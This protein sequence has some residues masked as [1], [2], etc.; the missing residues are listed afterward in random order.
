MNT[1]YTNLVI[2]FFL[3]CFG[4]KAQNNFTSFW[5]PLIS[6]NHKV[7]KNYEYNFGFE[8][9]S[10]LY[11]KNA[12]EFKVRQFDLSH[13]STFTIFHNQKLSLGV[14]YRYADEFEETQNEVRFT[15]QYNFTYNPHV[16]R[17]GHRVRAEQHIKSENT[18]HRFRYRFALDF[19]LSGEK[20]D[21][22]ESYMVT[23]AEMLY[24]IANNIVPELDTRL[25]LEIGWLLNNNFKLQTGLE[26]RLENFNNQPGHIL[27]LLTE[28]AISF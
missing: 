2:L 10:I 22:G 4:T 11:R 3:V 5:E 14:M 19:P 7:N 21:I 1:S 24:S 18:I 8:K 13:F 28:A 23:S 20:L 9:R 6:L 25:N 27:M 12:V 16:I 26:Y 17:Y 15:E